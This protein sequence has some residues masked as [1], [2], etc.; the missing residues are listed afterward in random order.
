MDN[1][2][3]RTLRTVATLAV[4]SFSLLGSPR[5]SPGQEQ[6]RFG[7]TFIQFLASHGDWG[8]DSWTDLFRGFKQLGLSEVVVQWSLFD[9]TAFYPSAN[10]KSVPQ[11]PLETILRLGDA[12]RIKVFVGLAHD[13]G[14]WSKIRREPA[15]VG[16]YLRRLRHRSEKVAVELAP[17]VRSHPSFGGWYLPEE[18]EDGSWRDPET[19]QIL[20]DHL[21]A[22][23]VSLKAVTPGCEVAISGFSN[24]RSD[25]RAFEEFWR[26]LLARADAD[27][28]LF[29]DGIGTGKIGLDHLELYLNAIRKAVDARSRKLQVVVE[30]FRQVS[31]PP[32]D[33][34][35]PFRAVPAPV[36]R[37]VHQANLAAKYST[38]PVVVF[39]VPDYMSPFGGQEADRLYRAY[40][41]R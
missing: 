25:P 39:S 1:T 13:P 37:I 35:T 5:A 12:N 20:F 36:E 38:L 28:L 18:I 2:R 24:A 21:R 4:L 30:V 10:Y 14:F 17:M 40:L 8:A 15:L 29:Q 16:V 31:G 23:V 9:D 6:A 7:G 26:I 32:F 22:S 41:E 3:W 34:K 27:R 11:P 19:R 33:D